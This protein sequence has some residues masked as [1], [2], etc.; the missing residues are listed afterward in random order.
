[1]QLAKGAWRSWSFQ[2][3]ALLAVLMALEQ[4]MPGIKDHVSEAAYDWVK[5]VVGVSIPAVRYLRQE[6]MHDSE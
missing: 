1:M 5:F 6:A 2:L 4:V 3:G